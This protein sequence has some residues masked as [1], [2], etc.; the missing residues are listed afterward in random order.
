MDVTVEVLDESDHVINR[1]VVT[2]V[3]FRL[4][5]CTKLTGSIYSAS[6]SASSFLLEPEWLETQEI[7]F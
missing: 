6:S 1:K 7:N 3:P 2:N 4:N 5:R